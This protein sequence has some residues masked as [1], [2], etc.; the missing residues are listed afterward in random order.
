M[1]ILFLS[2]LRENKESKRE[3]IKSHMSFQNNIRNKEN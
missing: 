1:N 3:F 2:Q